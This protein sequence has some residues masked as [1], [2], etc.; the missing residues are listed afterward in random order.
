MR[1][2]LESDAASLKPLLGCINPK[3]YMFLASAW[4]ACPEQVLN[5]CMYAMQGIRIIIYN[6]IPLLSFYE[7]AIIWPQRLI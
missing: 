2:C 6:N 4:G 7:D 5:L 1:R 3:L